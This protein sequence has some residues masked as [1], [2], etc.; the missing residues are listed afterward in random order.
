MTTRAITWVWDHSESR[1]ID[2]LVLLALADEAS[3][4]GRCSSAVKT[5]A[6]KAGVDVRT[7]QRSLQRLCQ[8]GG[9]LALVA[10]EAGPHGTRVYRMRLDPR[11][12]QV[13]ESHPAQG[14][15]RQ[16]DTRRRVTPPAESHPP[17]AGQTVTDLPLPP[18]ERHPSSTNNQ[19]LKTSPSAGKPPTSTADPRF[20]DWWNAVPKKVGKADALRKY[21]AAIKGGATAEQL[22]AGIRRYAESVRGKELQF[23]CHPATW[24]HQG[25]WDDE[26]PRPAGDGPSWMDARSAG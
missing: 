10:G 14:H 21:A 19:E 6:R 13:T 20:M 23:V 24:L 22:L 3:E 26:L 12:Q 9:D 1:G 25:R 17:K 5:L 7:V 16:A 11:A 15:P 18:A 8:P 2:R 4:S